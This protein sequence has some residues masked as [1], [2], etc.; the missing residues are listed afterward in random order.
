MAEAP[1]FYGALVVA[2]ALGILLAF[3]GISTIRL[4]FIAGIIGGI[5]TPLGLTAL[6]RIAGDR[7]LMRGKP[8]GRPM[9]IAGWAT[10]VSIGALSLVFIVVQVTRA[11]G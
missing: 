2:V 7:R 9:L 11:V 6:L 3:S 1:R 8:V 10:T 4:L 5:A